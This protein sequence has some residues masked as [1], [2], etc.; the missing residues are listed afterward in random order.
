MSGAP[1]HSFL[2]K[3]EIAISLLRIYMHHGNPEES[4][5]TPLF[6]DFFKFFPELTMEQQMNI[7]IDITEMNSKYDYPNTWNDL[8]FAVDDDYMPVH[9]RF[10]D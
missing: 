9:P 5:L 3:M 4:M 10:H 1:P 7:F 2:S 8:E 6:L